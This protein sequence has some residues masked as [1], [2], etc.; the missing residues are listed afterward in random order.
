MRARR[1]PDQRRRKRPHE[2]FRKDVVHGGPLRS[3]DRW[4]RI[5][6]RDRSGASEDDWR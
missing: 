2:G 5:Q 4:R 6:D 3:I 1:G